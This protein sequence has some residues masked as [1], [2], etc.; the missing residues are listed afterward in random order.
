MK[1]SDEKN[2]NNLTENRRKDQ[3]KD[4]SYIVLQ[5]QLTSEVFCV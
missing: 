2:S 3:R 1:S 4:F 5:T